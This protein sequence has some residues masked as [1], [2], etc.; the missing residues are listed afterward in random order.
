V[1]AHGIQPKALARAFGADVWRHRRRV[2][3]AFACA[4]GSVAADILSP[5]P[6]KVIIDRVLGV[7]P[8]HGWLRD[9]ASPMGRDGLVALLAGVFVAVTVAGAVATMFERLLTARVRERLSLELR[10]RLLGHLQALPPTVRSSHRSGELV[11]RIVGDVDLFVRLLTKTL[12]LLARYTATALGTLAAMWW[13]APRLALVN[14]ALLPGLYLLVRRYGTSLTATTR[15]KRRCEGEVAGLAQEIVRGLPA[16]QALGGDRHARGRFKE[17]NARSL[18]AGVKA[19][20]A[21][22][23]M[24][25][26]FDI[27]RGVAVALVTAGG[28]ALVLRGR[29]TVGDL[30]VVV[31]YV[32]QLLKPVDKINDVTDSLMRGLVAGERLVALLAQTPLVQDAPGARDVGRAVGH[33]ELRDVWFAYPGADRGRPVLRGAN[34]RVAPGQLAVLVGASGAGKSTLLSLLV[35][36]FDPTAGTILLDGRPLPTITLRSLRAQIAIMTQETHLFSGTIRESLTPSGAAVDDEEMWSVL[37]LVALDGFVA[38][39]PN[40]L[41]T[42]LGEDAL[43][44]SG[45]QRQRLSLARAFLLDRPILLLDEPLSNVDPESAEVI[46]DA[47]RQ[48]RRSR[49][50]IAIT[51]QLALAEIGDVVLRLENGRIVEERP[52]VA[53][54]AGWPA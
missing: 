13:I 45:G 44:L 19:T 21:A 22:A 29:L 17:T 15:D 47:L 5:W 54:A 52:R 11:L 31:A 9:V 53:V 48:M 7:K 42:R 35:R 39:L 3:L 50:C 28:A 38:A 24:E 30:T 32:T 8:L 12:P 27:A 16:T 40:G 33:L 41:E 10:D 4:F 46:M 14:V 2:G 25:Q 34:L 26:A 43:D 18:R 51:H 49:T 20:R 1:S 37:R 23:R 36:L 6:L